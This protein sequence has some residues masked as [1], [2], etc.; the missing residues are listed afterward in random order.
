MLRSCV[1]T[2]EESTAKQIPSSEILTNSAK[3]TQ[4]SLRYKICG[5]RNVE[6]HSH[7]C[8]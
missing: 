8:T 7:G 6:R 4:Q 1:Q 3:N 2:N 5:R